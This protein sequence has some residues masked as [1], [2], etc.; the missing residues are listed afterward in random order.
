MA[1]MNVTV[2]KLVIMAMKMIVM[3]MLNKCSWD[4]RYSRYELA[5]FQHFKYVAQSI[6]YSAHKA[7][8]HD[9]SLFISAVK[10][11]G[12]VFISSTDFIF[13]WLH[14]SWRTLVAFLCEVSETFVF[15]QL[16]VLLG[17]GGR[18]VTRPLPTQDSRTHKYEDKHPYFEWH[19]NPRSQ[20]SDGQDPR[21][22]S[23]RLATQ[24]PT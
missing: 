20:Y 1:M 3:M 7:Y 19:S 5:I 18:P 21:L 4:M 23:D 13:L 15:Q 24:K 16:V 14:C 12:T 17:W 6:W 2:L 8:K 10:E 22:C 9:S 11:I